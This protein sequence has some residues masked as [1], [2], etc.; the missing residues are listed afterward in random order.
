MRY[1][2]FEFGD[3][4]RDAH[5]S[6]VQFPPEIMEK[7]STWVKNPKDFFVFC[8]SAGVGKTYLAAALCR[9]FLDRGKE[10]YYITERQLFNK[11]RSIIQ[12]DWDY[13]FEIKKMSQ[14]PFFILDDIGS[15]QMTEWQKEVLFSFVDHR[16]KYSY[17]TVI[18]SNLFLKDMIEEF[19][20]RFV[21]RLKDKRNT[22]VELNWI[23][24]RQE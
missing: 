14:F 3:K 18:T 1:E 7:I 21:S 9:E 12:K 16:S 20:L 6:K 2:D 24:K 15:S 8:G 23:D 19:S 11:L 10:I 22:I 17:P 5:L 13:E 4:Y